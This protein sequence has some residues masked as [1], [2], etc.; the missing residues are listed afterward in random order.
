[1]KQYM[2]LCNENSLAYLS[3]LL[4]PDRIQF[5]EVQGMLLDHNPGFQAI[6]TPV[7][8]AVAEQPVTDN[9]E[10]PVN[11]EVQP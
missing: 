5:V 6:V 3:A 8:Q 4:H 9:T 2:I 11:L 10:T 1:M 7:L